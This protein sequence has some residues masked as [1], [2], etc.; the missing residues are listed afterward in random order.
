M[1]HIMIHDLFYIFK[2]I[3]FVL[4]YYI[5]FQR[6][7]ID[8]T[9]CFVFQ[10]FLRQYLIFCWHSLL[11]FAQAFMGFKYLDLNWEYHVLVVFFIFE[12]DL[13][14]I[15]ISWHIFHHHLACICSFLISIPFA[16]I[17][18]RDSWHIFCQ[19]LHNHYNL[20]DIKWY[21]YHHRFDPKKLDHSMFGKF[22]FT[23]GL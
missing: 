10:Q 7:Y 9:V 3:V 2:I 5:Y 19:V 18:R 12:T 1:A 13:H 21:T 20:L 6:I 16:Y 8:W 11:C 14:K 15:Y 17:F 23:F 4:S 22:D